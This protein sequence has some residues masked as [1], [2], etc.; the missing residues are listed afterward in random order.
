METIP[1]YIL[2]GGQSSRFGRDKARADVLGQPLIVRLAADLAPVAER[3][4]VI[5]DVEDKYA[6][7][8]LQTLCDLE[9]GL[10]PLGGLQA[11]LV[12]GA[13]SGAATVLG[14]AGG[15]GGE[16]DD[17]GDGYIAVVSCDWVGARA[18]WIEML[19][20]SAAEGMAAAPGGRPAPAVAFKGERWEPL[21]ALYHTS[22]RMQVE[23]AVESGQRS[24][25][26]LLDT[27]GARAVP[28]PG[29]W[30]AMAQVNAPE[31]L[32]AWLARQG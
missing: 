25:W 22:I 3:V 32:A 7:L 8:G 1:V 12:D 14:G 20:R 13:V 4:T 17:L 21:F 19:W 15:A 2:A 9:P 27:L 24:L 30:N 10:G 5:A 16:D 29:D 23:A 6:D 26:R 18:A 11:A 31:A 28:L